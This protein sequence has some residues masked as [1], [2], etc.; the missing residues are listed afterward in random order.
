MKKISK[1]TE[2]DLVR[3]INK[4]IKEQAA[5]IQQMAKQVAKQ[6]SPTAPSP[7][8]SPVPPKKQSSGNQYGPYCKIGSSQGIINQHT[9]GTSGP[10]VNLG[11]TGFG[12]FDASGKLICK[13][14][15]KHTRGGYVTTASR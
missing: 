8:N 4:V 5:P 14:S 12:L 13:I 7:A 6:T 9:T 2:Q 11:E 1:L 10:N 15:T 3:L